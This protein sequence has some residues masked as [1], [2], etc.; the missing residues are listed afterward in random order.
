M[1]IEYDETADAL[2]ITLRDQPWA[3]SRALDDTRNIDYSATGEVIGVELL[4]ASHGVDLSGVP[5]SNRIE[6]A[7]LG[8]SFKVYA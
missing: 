8:R 4:C 2:H 7:L 1:K 3:S 5:E 6:K